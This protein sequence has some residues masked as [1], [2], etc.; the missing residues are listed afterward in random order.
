KDAIDGAT[1]NDGATNAGQ[2]GKT[3]IEQVVP[4]SLEDAKKA[5]KDAVD[6]DAAKQKEL[7]NNSNNLSA[8]EKQELTNKVD[9]AT[10]T[11]KDAIDGATTN[12]GAT[13]AGQD[14]KTAIEAVTV[15]TDSDVKKNAN[16]DLDNTADAA[17]K[18]ID[19]TSGL[20]AD[21]KQTAKDQIDQAVTD[22]QGNIKK[23]SDNQGVANA[24]DAGKLAI[25][26][27]AAN[28]AIDEA[29]NKKKSE[30]NGATNLDQP[31]KDKLIKEATDAADKAKD[32]INKATTNKAVATEQTKGSNAID[33]V[34]VPSLTDSQTAAK[35]AIDDALNKKKS[36]ING[37]TNLDQPT[38]DHL[39]KE[40]T[41]AADK[42]KN[43]IDQATTA[44]AIKKAQDD[45]ISNI[46]NLNQGT[47]ATKNKPVIPASKIPVG[48]QVT[49][50]IITGDDYTYDDAYN[51][52]YQVIIKANAVQ[53]YTLPKGNLTKE[54]K[55]VHDTTLT[56]LE[57]KKID[58]QV[59][60][61]IGTNRWIMAATTIKVGEPEN[62]K[63]KR[64]SKTTKT[65]AI[66]WV[67]KLAIYNNVNGKMT[68]KHLTRGTKVRIYAIATVNGGEWY[69]VGKNKWIPAAGVHELTV[70]P[71]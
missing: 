55:L 49:T 41:D 31:T 40:A 1:T 48:D 7:I 38:K 12:D 23:A 33:A 43:A 6:K 27:D 17:K 14:G 21:Q 8:S 60:Y 71:L 67:N 24:T 63:L 51:D 56:V 39:I 26:K 37:A 42:A 62:F 64:L 68:K 53:V 28:A 52:F 69:K 20:T 25:D 22:A 19:E 18:A 46:N 65:T 29:L 47:D 44:D 45:G 50:V 34:K 36:E 15:P 5:A 30:I 10:Q 61:R 11:A 58:G 2:D 35:Q 32:A 70:E 59:W 9:S 13:N 16:S 57:T 66:V 54:K 3:A 4:T